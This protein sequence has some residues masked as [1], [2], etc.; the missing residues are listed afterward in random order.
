[1]LCFTVAGMRHLISKEVAIIIS[2]YSCIKPNS[3]Y[4]VGS[5]SDAL[6]LLYS[7]ENLYVFSKNVNFLLITGMSPIAGS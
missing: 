7:K 6:Y 3:Q 1:M 5:N 2:F 4:L